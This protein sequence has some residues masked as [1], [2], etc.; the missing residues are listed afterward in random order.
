MT[1]APST[2]SPPAAAD[3]EPTHAPEPWE[4]DVIAAYGL[5]RE[6]AAE[7]D[8]L[9][10]QSLKRSGLP[11][12]MFELL[13]RLA[14]SPGERQ[15]LTSLARELTVTTG[16]VTRLVDRA[17]TLGLVRREPCPEDARGSFAVLTEEGKLRLRDALPD[18][19]LE[20]GSLW[21]SQLGDE[22]DVVLGRLRRV[23]DNA[24][25][26]PNG[27]SHLGGLSRG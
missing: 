18:H 12:A 16:G 6:A 11:M 5:L 7:L 17:E 13:V 8:Q 3:A 15:R 20:I 27:R 24:R 26:W 4:S 10:R 25:R 22:R 23:R 2:C 1:I 19:L 21:T 9:M 14:R